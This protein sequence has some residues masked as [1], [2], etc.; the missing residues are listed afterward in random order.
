MLPRE[1][2][3][4]FSLQS[5]FCCY[6]PESFSNPNPMWLPLQKPHAKKSTLKSTYSLSQ[7]LK[8]QKK[9]KIKKMME[10][11]NLILALLI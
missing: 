5:I 11:P 6:V 4:G 3:V 2:G 10:F 1:M 7:W 8:K 9:T